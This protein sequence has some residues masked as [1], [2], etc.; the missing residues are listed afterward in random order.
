MSLICRPASLLLS[1]NQ[2]ERKIIKTKKGVFQGGG[3]S[4][5]IFAIYIDPLAN[6]LNGLTSSHRPAA[7]FYADDIKLNPRNVKEAQNLLNICSDYAKTLK[8]Q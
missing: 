8:L 6:A 3:I 4:A 5:F 2:S 1:V 7:L